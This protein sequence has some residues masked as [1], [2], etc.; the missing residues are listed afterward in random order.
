MVI[1]AQREQL[2]ITADE[3]ATRGRQ[4]RSHSETGVKDGDNRRKD[5]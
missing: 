5:G 3:K 1:S 2:M 4:D